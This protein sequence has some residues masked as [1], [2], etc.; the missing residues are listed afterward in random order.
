LIQSQPERKVAFSITDGIHVLGDALLLR[1]VLEN[2]MGNA[3]KYTSSHASANIEFGVAMQPDGSEAYFV[4]DDGAGF[5]MAYADKLFGVFQRLHSKK[6]FPGIGIGL[7]T[8]Q[9]IIHRHNG[10]VWAE[11]VEDKSTSFYFTVGKEIE[12]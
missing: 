9:R 5:D 8:V 6:E 1:S 12:A 10:H 7:A 11:S 3:W 2:L 4:R